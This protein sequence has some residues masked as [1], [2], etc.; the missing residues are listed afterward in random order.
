MQEMAHHQFCP[1]QA[2]R[3]HD[4]L[5]STATNFSRPPKEFCK[6]QGVHTFKSL[7][8]GLAQSKIFKT[9]S[10]TQGR[11]RP[12]SKAGKCNGMGSELL[13]KLAMLSSKTGKTHTLAPVC[14]GPMLHNH[15]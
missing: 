12:V 7:V 11:T 4:A 3:S 1:M 10:L 9:L 8:P 13:L 15:A 2:T 14:P 5:Y 6:Q